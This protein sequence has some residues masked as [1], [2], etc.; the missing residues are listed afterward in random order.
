MYRPD[1]M[2]DMT[3]QVIVVIPSERDGGS[4]GAHM[5]DSTIRR[6]LKANAIFSA[7]SGL[8]LAAGAVPMSDLIGAPTWL[9]LVVGIGLLPWA[10]LVWRYSTRDEIRTAEAWSVVVGDEIWLV[11]TI[12]L[13][14]MYPT[15]LTAEGNAL[16]AVVGLIVA[17]FAV[18][19]MMGIRAMKGRTVQATP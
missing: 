4:K 13:L 9:T 10:A 19:Q 6:A 2:K 16:A 1:R 15:A 3:C 14:L 17:A 11:G 18:A 12:V 8:V 5:N 7:V